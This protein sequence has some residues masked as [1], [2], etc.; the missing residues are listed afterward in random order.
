MAVLIRDIYEAFD[1]FHSSLYRREFRKTLN[2]H[3]WGEQDL[4]PLLRTFL[5]GYFGESLVPEAKAKLPGG[6]SGYGRLDFT[7]DGVG[8]EFAVRKPRSPKS[9]VQNGVNSPEVKKLMKH[10]GRAGLVLFD[11]SGDP[12][13]KDELDR[14]RELPSLGKESHRTSSF[15]VMYFFTT[16]GRPRKRG[17]IAKRIRA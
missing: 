15:N 17:C 9:S 10:D 11:L 16:T 8:V 14:F 3:Q 13:T 2:L 1:L 4:L 12:L 7:I 5:L 6:L